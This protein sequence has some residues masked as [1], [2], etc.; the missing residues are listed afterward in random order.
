MVDAVQA[1][2]SDVCVWEHVCMLVCFWLVVRNQKEVRRKLLAQ[3]YMSSSS[4]RRTENHEWKKKRMEG[5]RDSRSV[6]AMQGRRSLM[7]LWSTVSSF[8][9]KDVRCPAL[10]LMLMWMN[11]RKD[12][13][14]FTAEACV[15]INKLQQTVIFFRSACESA[16]VLKNTTAA[17]SWG[18]SKN[19][20]DRYKYSD[21]LHH[22]YTHKHTTIDICA[23]K[24]L[25]LNA[26][27]IA[28]SN[29]SRFIWNLCDLVL[30]HL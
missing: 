12:T 14:S 22:T 7:K 21:G 8:E 17:C 13:S 26:A 15:I 18:G 24:L 2:G 6:K 28:Y 11:G 23:C 19:K 27:V 30:N 4:D 20:T 25:H 10:R 3:S 5:Y 16:A 1:N 9:D 29:H